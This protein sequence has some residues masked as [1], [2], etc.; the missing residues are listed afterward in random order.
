MK[1]FQIVL[2]VTL[3]VVFG[4]FPVDAQEDDLEWWQTTVLY[5]IYP[6]SFQDSDGDGVGDLK[7][8]TSRLEHIVDA[9]VG[10]I[11]LSPIFVSPGVDFGY[12]IANFTAIDP[13]FGTLED[14]IDLKAKADKLGLKV[15]LDLVPNHTSNESVWFQQSVDKVD[16]YTDYYVWADPIYVNDTRNP[17]NNWLSNFGG[18]AWEWREERQQYYLHQ[19]A[20]QQADLNYRSPAVVEEVKV[21]S[22]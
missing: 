18:S 7:G 13:L 20:I 2:L 21:I 9:G 4:T 14:L 10:A 12:D 17:P 11:W 6:R 1:Y 3:G 22:H 15:L 8:I 16:P 5:Q 19:F